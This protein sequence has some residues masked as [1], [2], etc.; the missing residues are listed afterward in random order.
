[1]RGMTKACL[2]LVA[3]LS[4]APCS[5]SDQ[6]ETDP[7]NL[8]GELTKDFGPVDGSLGATTGN[9]EE[10]GR[11]VRDNPGKVR[12]VITLQ[13]HKKLPVKA[14]VDFR[15]DVIVIELYREDGTLRATDT[16]EGHARERLLNVLDGESVNMTPAGK[17]MGK[18]QEFD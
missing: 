2:F 9:L 7:S 11:M 4:L 13:A 17:R 1:M 6:P 16:W 3:L 10:L 14:W 5:C 15:K 18:R 12:Y 8:S